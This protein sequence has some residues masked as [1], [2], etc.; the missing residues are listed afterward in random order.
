[1]MGACVLAIMIDLFS[2]WSFHLFMGAVRI[3]DFI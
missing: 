3:A 2:M 1:M